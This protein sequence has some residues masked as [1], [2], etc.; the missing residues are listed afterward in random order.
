VIGELLP[1]HVRFLDR[2]YAES[3]F[4]VSG[5][6]SPRTGGIILA[7]AKDER[8]IWSL[9]EQDPFYVNGAAEYEV[10][11]FSPTKYDPG[12]TSYI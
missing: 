6:R 8:E 12:F 4:I 10:I 7:R 3:W 9:I 5:R 1:P 11:E 2:C